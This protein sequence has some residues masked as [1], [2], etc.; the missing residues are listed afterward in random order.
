MPAFHRQAFSAR[1]EAAP[2]NIIS[3]E[4]LPQTG[5]DKAQAVVSVV[6]VLGP[7]AVAMTTSFI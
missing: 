7:A 2:H 4:A 3:P 6:L 1:S 5:R